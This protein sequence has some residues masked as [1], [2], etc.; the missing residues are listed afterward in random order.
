M[1]RIYGFFLLGI[2][3]ITLGSYQSF[4]GASPRQETPLTS[5]ESQVYSDFIESF[6]KTNFKFLSRATFP[7]DLSGVAKDA[8]CLQGLQL[9]GAYKGT[10]HSLVPE[11]L[12]GHSIHLVDEKEE[13]AILKQRDGDSEAREANSKTN[14]G[15]TKDPGVLALSEVIFDKSHHFA[16][17]KYAFLCGSHC[18][19]AAILVLENVGAG[20]VA[21]TRRPCSFAVNRDNPRP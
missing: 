11:V 16:V 15:T 20:W 10:M 14:S 8:A 2:G 6:S 1:K 19:S 5:E 7:L 17:L 3:I 4:A 18:N 21:T 13:V 12:R 9:E